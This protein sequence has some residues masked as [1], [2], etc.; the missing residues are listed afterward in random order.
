MASW[1]RVITTDDDSDYKNSNIS[2]TDIDANVSDTE[3]GFL[4]GVTSDIQTQINSASSSGGLSNEEVQ[5]IVGGM[6]SGNTETGI[7][8]TYDDSNNEIDFVVATQSDNNFT[9]TLKNKL[10]GIEASADVTDTA[11]VVSALTAGSNVSIANDGTISATNTNTQL[12]TEEVQ[13]IVGGMVSSN[14]ETRIG[15]TYDDT[16]GK[17]NF[18]VDD[19]TTDNNTFRTV[20]V[21]TNGDGT[22]DNTLTATENLRFVKGSN[23]SLSESAGKVTISGTGDTTYTAGTGMSLSAGNQFSIG[24]DVSTTANVE[25]DRLDVDAVRIDGGTITVTNANTHL[26][27]AGGSNAQVRCQDD[28]HVNGNLTVSGTTTTI[29]TET[30]Q[31]A[32]NTILLNSNA[33]G[34]P[35]EDGGIEI[36]RGSRANVNFIWDES[37]LEW[38]SQV[39]KS[40]AND[41]TNYNG[42]VPVIERASTGTSG[43]DTTVGSMF[44][45]TGT[46]NFYIYS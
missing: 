43:S 46:G 27:I 30:I 6:L 42:K 37:A 26:D 39:Y 13:D 23:I 17:I 31:L 7:T 8:V 28:F 45:N 18:V 12:T 1:K 29:T 9:T 24:Q 38:T 33:S 19:M 44:I 14:T 34:T 22:V 40:S 15:V 10:D 25:F 11:N 5:D 16:N 20:E 2:A 3:F 32:D 35:T 21:D 4:S 41:T 36:E